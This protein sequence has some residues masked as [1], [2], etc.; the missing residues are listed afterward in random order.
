MCESW[1]WALQVLTVIGK[2][3]IMLLEWRCFSAAQIW[4][5]F[6]AANILWT[7]EM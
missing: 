2:L 4:C 1:W 7:W 5:A 6:R 3:F